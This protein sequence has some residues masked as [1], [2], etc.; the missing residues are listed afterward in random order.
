LKISSS[1]DHPDQFSIT[2]ND[3]FSSS[4]SGFFFLTNAHAT[5]VVGIMPKKEYPAKNLP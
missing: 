1:I 5:R 3:H 4:A 2:A